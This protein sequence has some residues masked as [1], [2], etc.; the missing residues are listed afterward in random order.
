M[1]VKIKKIKEENEDDEYV[2]SSQSLTPLLL[3]RL[4]ERM[5][6]SLSSLVLLLLLLLLLRCVRVFF[7]LTRT[8][9]QT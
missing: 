1:M 4:D 6:I 3:P 9:V 5:N 2:K 7:N 8:H